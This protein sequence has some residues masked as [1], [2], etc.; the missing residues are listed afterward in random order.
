[1]KKTIIACICLLGISTLSWAQEE[2][3]EESLMDSEE[4]AIVE[5]ETS[6]DIADKTET[7]P[8]TK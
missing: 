7:S 1:M 2:P 5:E 4:V 3:C 6:A 8:A